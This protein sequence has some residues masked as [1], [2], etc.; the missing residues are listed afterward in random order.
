[1]RLQYENPQAE[2]LLFLAREPLASEN[3]NA[4]ALIDDHLSVGDTPGFTED[5]EDW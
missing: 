5:V 3:I 2:I 4:P 1:M